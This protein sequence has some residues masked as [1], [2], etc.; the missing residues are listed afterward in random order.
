M[1][2]RDRPRTPRR[3]PLTRVDV[4]SSRA[5]A[6]RILATV[7]MVAAIV[8]GAIALAVSRSDTAQDDAGRAAAR[9]E[10]VQKRA[11]TKRET[12]QLRRSTWATRRLLLANRRLVRANRR[13]I[14]S[15]ERLLVQARI[16]R[17]S[18]SGL[19]LARRGATGATGAT[20]AM[21]GA[22]TPA[23]ATTALQLRAALGPLLPA[24]VAAYCAGGA[25][26]GADGL[27]GVAGTQGPPPSDAQVQ[28]AAQAAV[29]EYCATGACTPPPPAGPL[30]CVDS[31]DHVTFNCAPTP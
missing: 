28:A 4:V 19:T 9:V 10:S 7:V 30:T 22:G 14:T 11:A 31:G 20:G 17:R 12:E 13:I 1:S 21:G 29:A 27:N 6:L 24:V 15:L 16:A 23:A 25:C 3:S 26:A 5:L 2:R 18:R 8:G